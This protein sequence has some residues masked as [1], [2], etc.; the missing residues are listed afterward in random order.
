[1][2]SASKSEAECCAVCSRML[3][4]LH[5]HP[6]CAAGVGAAGALSAV[7]TPVPKAARVRVPPTAFFNSS[8]NQLLSLVSA[9]LLDYEATT[10]ADAKAPGTEQ[11]ERPA[12]LTPTSKSIFLYLRL[13]RTGLQ[14]LTLTTS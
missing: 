3:Q 5:D 12:L 8:I 1:M 6:H 7:A 14:R 2:G 4:R 11:L 10:P 13:S 9:L